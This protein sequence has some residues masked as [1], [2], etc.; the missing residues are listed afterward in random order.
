MEFRRCSSD[1]FVFVIEQHGEIAMIPPGRRRRPRA[2]EPAGDG[3]IADTA[4][5]P[6]DPAQALLRDVRAFGF[7]ADQCGIA[8]AVA[9][10][11]GVPARR[12]R[13]RL[14]VVHRHPREGLADVAARLRRISI[15]AGAFG[16]DVDEAD[17]KSTRLY[18]SH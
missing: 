9:L 5:M 2:F 4:L 16:V 10:A 12:Q 17:R 14:L 3:V 8:R 15:A 13:E 7:G 11:E 18:S 6:A 1:L